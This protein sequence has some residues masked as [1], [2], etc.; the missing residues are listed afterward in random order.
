MIVSHEHR[1]IFLKPRKVAGTSFEIALSKYLSGSD[2]VTPISPED[3]AIRARLGFAGARNF[4]YPLVTLLGGKLGAL[5]GRRFPRY[6]NHM[7][8]SLAKARLPARVWDGYRKL[9]LVRNPWD[10]AVSLFFWRIQG[11][12][13]DVGSFTA[14]FQASPDLLDHNHANYMIDG[15]DVIDRYVRYE[16]F[17]E[18]MRALERDI[19]ALAGLWDTFRSIKAKATSRGRSFGTAEIFA[20]NPEIDALVRQRNAWE[21]ARF[22]YRLG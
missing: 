21:I 3:E 9:T 2:I 22:G 15:R 11:T 12:G 5:V 19:P 1:F 14:F 7:S 13:A 20:A 16:Q 8:A 10:R 6:F 18:D 17:E 4:D